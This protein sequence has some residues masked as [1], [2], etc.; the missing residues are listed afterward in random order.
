MIRYGTSEEMYT[1]IKEGTPRKAV[2]QTR[3]IRPAQ[4]LYMRISINY[5]TT[6]SAKSITVRRL[7]M[8]RS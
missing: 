8:V 2:G 5:S 7:A 6:G 1:L 3:R 4:H